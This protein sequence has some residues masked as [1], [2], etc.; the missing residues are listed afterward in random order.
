[1]KST[2]ADSLV[3][4]AK[5]TPQEIDQLR[6]GQT[7]ALRFSA[8]NQRTTPQI[9]GAVSRVSAD[10]S[11]D[12]RTGMS[13]YTVRIATSQAEINKLGGVRLVPGM[14]VEAF[15]ETGERTVLSYLIKPMRDQITRAFREK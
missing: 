4:E 6:P 7:A 10:I 13:Y 5:V 3:V 15:I 14:P 1:M 9:I 8:F 12:Q 2:K 11:T